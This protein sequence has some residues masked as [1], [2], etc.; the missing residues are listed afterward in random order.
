MWLIFME[1][2][3]QPKKR[4][5]INWKELWS[6]RELFYYFTWRDIKVRYKQTLLG[7]SWAIIQPFATMVVFTLFFNHVA[8]IK[9]GAVPYAIFSYTGLLFWNYFAS[10]LS[11][12]SNSLVGNQGV[13]TKIYFPRIIIPASATLLGVVDFFFAAIV[14]AGLAFYYHIAPGTEGLLMILPMLILSVIAALGVGTLFAALNVKYRDVRSIVPFI[15]QIGLF[16]TPVIYPVSLVPHKYQWIL[17]LN[18]MS[19][20]INT[21]RSGLLHQGSINWAQLGISCV[22]AFILLWIGI[23][24]FKRTERQFADII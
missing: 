8:G 23:A 15:V 9:S 20:V 18:P 2:I 12:V 1:I 13:I 6:Y 22:S 24:Y 16:V 4:T 11:Q 14:F 3:I 5:Q 17:S 19:S 10:A 21:M 7:A